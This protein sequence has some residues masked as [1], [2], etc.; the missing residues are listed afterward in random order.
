MKGSVVTIG[1]FDGVHLGHQ[2]IVRVAI[3]QAVALGAEPIAFTF[4]PHP[5]SVLRPDRAPALLL[6]YDEK[7]DTLLSLGISRVVEQPFDLAFS[8]TTP[9]E[10][11]R[12]T[13][14]GAL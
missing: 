10:F 12:G 14:L 13:L 9:Q 6:T 2:E 11:F 7:R 3:G 4:R 5:Q 8:K 1:N